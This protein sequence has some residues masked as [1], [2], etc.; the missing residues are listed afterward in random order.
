MKTTGSSRG[1]GLG[2]AHIEGLLLGSCCVEECGL[3]IYV[4]VW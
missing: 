3:S 1:V 2:M 4:V